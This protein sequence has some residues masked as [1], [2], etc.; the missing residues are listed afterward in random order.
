MQII[1]CVKQ[2]QRLHDIIITLRNLLGYVIQTSRAPDEK[3]LTWVALEGI[4][5]LLQHL[6]WKT[7]ISSEKYSTGQC[8]HCAHHQ[9]QRALS[10]AVFFLPFKKYIIQMMRL[11]RW[12][13][14]A[15]THTLLVTLWWS[16]DQLWHHPN[17]HLNFY[18]PARP[19]E[20]IIFSDLE[21]HTHMDISLHF[22]QP[23]QVILPFKLCWAVQAF[24]VISSL[25]CFVFRND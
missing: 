3:M 23:L 11:H 5:D 8:V 15:Y 24:Q 2:R 17:L 4:N 19:P 6:F 9:K 14:D 1:I 12:V 22:Y 10:C 25:C 13:H 16:T 7:L 21:T 18:P 20:F